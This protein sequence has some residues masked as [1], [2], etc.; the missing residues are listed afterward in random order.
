[1]EPND[2][3]NDLRHKLEA[4]TRTVELLRPHFEKSEKRGRILKNSDRSAHEQ[5]K[6]NMVE[7]KSLV[8]GLER[9][10]DEFLS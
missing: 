5:L 9:A 8:T 4:A 1:M 7:A 6:K 3:L 2:L 10:I